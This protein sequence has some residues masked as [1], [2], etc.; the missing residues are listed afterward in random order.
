MSAGRS[1][2]CSIE[3][4]GAV[5][6]WG[7]HSLGQRGNGL[8]T[9]SAI[10]VETLMPT[11]CQGAILAPSRSHACAMANDE[12]SWCWGDNGFRHLGAGEGRFL[13]ET[14]PVP[15]SGGSF[16]WVGERAVFGLIDRD[17]FASGRHVL[18]A[19]YTPGSNPAEQGPLRLQI[20]VRAGR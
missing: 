1:D 5:Y 18:R 8:Q 7:L 10:P 11:S 19:E 16:A 9:P 13:A 3:A 4:L 2:P 12:H 17:G 20:R 14:T 6:C 15:V